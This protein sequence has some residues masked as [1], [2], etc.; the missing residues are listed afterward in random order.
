ML[1]R[2]QKMFVHRLGNKVACI[3][4]SLHAVA[5]VQNPILAADTVELRMDNEHGLG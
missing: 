4:A 2:N 5:H 1:Y 3:C